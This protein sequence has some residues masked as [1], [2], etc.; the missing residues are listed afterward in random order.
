MENKVVSYIVDAETGET[1]NEIRQGDRH[2]I[3]RKESI[4][5]LSQHQDWRIEHFYKG[6]TDEIRKLMRELSIN[7]KAFLFSVAV[8]VGYE[9]CCIK[10]SNGKDITTED[11][12]NLTG[13]SRNVFY[14]TVKELAKKDI[15]YIGKNSK[16]RQYF[17]NPW[18]FCK[19]NRINKVLRTMFKNYKVRICGNIPWK[20]LP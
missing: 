20:N 19:G 16:N 7:E 12:I 14:E 15:I 4:D 11:L 3:V 9:D 8:Y 10:Y 17:V 1:Y 18:L 6:H 2:K 5:Y 13:L